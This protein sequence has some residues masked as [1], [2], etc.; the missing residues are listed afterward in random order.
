MNGSAEALLRHETTEEEVPED[1]EG[2]LSAAPGHDFKHLIEAQPEAVIRCMPSTAHI[3]L[4]RT[5]FAS[6]SA[7]S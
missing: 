1:L 7:Y 2:G 6:R 5:L 3:R 4:S